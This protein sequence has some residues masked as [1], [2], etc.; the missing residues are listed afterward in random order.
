MGDA[1]I[2]EIV[3]AH[4]ATDAAPEDWDWKALDDAFF[5]QFS[6][7][8]NFRE[9]GN[10]H[11]I[12]HPTTWSRSPVERVRALYDEREQN[13]TP[14]VMRHLEKV[15]MLQTIDS[16]WKDHL[17]AMDHL[18]EGIGLRGYAQKNP[19]QEYQKEGFTMFEALM[20]AMQLD[21]VEK[22]FSVQIVREQSVEQLEQQQRPQQVVMSHGGQTEQAPAPTLRPGRQ[23]ARPTRS[24][25]TTRVRAARARSTSAAT[26]SSPTFAS[27]MEGGRRD[28]RS[29]VTSALSRRIASDSATG[30]MRLRRSPTRHVLDRRRRRIPDGSDPGTASGE[31]LSLRRRL[32]R[33]AQGAGTQGPRP[34]RGRA[35]VAAAGVFTTNRVKAAPVVVSQE[36]VRRGHLQ[37]VTANSGSAN[38]FTG[39]A[40]TQTGA[41][42]PARRWRREIGC[43]PELVAPCSTGVIGHLYDLEKYRAGIRDAVAA[44]APDALRGFRPRDHDHR[45]ASQD[46]L[47]TASSSAAPK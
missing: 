1:L 34:D 43:A 26:A 45:H 31:R 22:V 19:L 17:L 25:A 3:K 32:R 47:G 8:L 40:G 5:K 4:V 10:G 24:A 44:L 37:A 29:R 16:L 38:C 46:G 30:R 15:V 9:S 18:K 7:R 12:D 13:F 39:K 28:P 23:N 6:F 21:V 41:T 2:E 33:I 14:P 11:A 42:I 35:P 20:G 27:L 36:R